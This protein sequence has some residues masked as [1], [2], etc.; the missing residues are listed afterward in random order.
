MEVV[1]RTYAPKCLLFKTS[2]SLMLEI[3]LNFSLFSLIK[4]H[5]SALAPLPYPYQREACVCCVRAWRLK[6]MVRAREEG[7][8]AKRAF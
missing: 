8:I 7:S 6:E 3:E 5:L 1:S 4:L 2:P